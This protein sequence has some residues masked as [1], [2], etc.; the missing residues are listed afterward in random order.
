MRSLN[1]GCWRD[2][3]EGFTNVDLKPPADVVHDLTV[4]PWPFED[5]SYDYILASDILEHLP[6]FASFM[7]ECHRVLTY[8]GVLD[9]IVPTPSDNFW[10]DPTHIRPY[11]P[12]TFHI[13][14][15]EGHEDDY[16][17]IAG[18]DDVETKLLPRP[19]VPALH[20]RLT[21]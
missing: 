1:L 14:C 3:R 15:T 7:N 18:W 16:L 20:A 5:E 10:L 21:K 17:G 8:G 11:L 4:V 12:D 6:D 13:F 9:V 2:Y 19:Q